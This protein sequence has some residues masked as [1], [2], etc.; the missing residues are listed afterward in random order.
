MHLQLRQEGD[1]KNTPYR[2][3]T[4]ENGSLL[5]FFSFFDGPWKA[6]GFSWVAVY[7]TSGTFFLSF[8]RSLLRTIRFPPVCQECIEWLVFDNSECTF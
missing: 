7:C 4:V 6:A 3:L 1:D 8:F 5:I 2:N